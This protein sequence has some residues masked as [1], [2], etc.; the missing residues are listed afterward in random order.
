MAEALSVV[1]AENTSVK[2]FFISLSFKK[3]QPCWGAGLEW[4]YQ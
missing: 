3:A 1:R 4:F 2:N